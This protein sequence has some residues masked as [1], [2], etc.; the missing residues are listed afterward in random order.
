[1][2]TGMYTKGYIE[3]SAIHQKHCVLDLNE[4]R[5]NLDEVLSDDL[6]KEYFALLRKWLSFTSNMDNDEFNEAVKKILVTNEQIQCHNKYM[7]YILYKVNSIPSPTTT[8]MPS[9]SMPVNVDYEIRS[10]AAELFVPDSGFMTS[11][12]SVAA[13]MNG[14]EAAD[15]AC[16]D[17]L[18]HACQVFIKNIIT[19]MISKKKGYKIRERKLQYGFNQ[20]IPDP[21]LRNYNSLEDYSQENKVEVEEDCDY[22][23]PMCKLSLERAEQQMAFAYTC[24]GGKTSSDNLLTTKLFYSTLR[25]NP[26]L[27]GS[28]SIQSVALFKL[29][30]HIDDE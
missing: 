24:A 12:I 21:L 30:L 16:T 14:M 1:M 9:S 20:P 11:R 15:P 29:G 10:A 17:L 26:K 23:K 19:A 22:F 27:L 13:W 4:A 25:D 8:S 18:L 3:F 5:K 6:R 28:H 2:A 7:Y